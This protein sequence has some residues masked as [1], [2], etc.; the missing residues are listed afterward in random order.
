[1]PAGTGLSP[2]TVSSSGCNNFLS[3]TGSEVPVPS[4][5]ALNGSG[6][7][8][9]VL[10][11]VSQNKIWEFWQFQ[12]NANAGYSACWGG[13]QP[14]NTFTGVFPNPFGLSASG[15][16]YGAITVTEAD[17]ASG[18]INHTIALGI[19]GCSGQVYPADRNDC[20]SHGNN[21][22]QPDEGQWFTWAPGT[23]MP[24]G[25]TPFGQMVFKTIQKYGLVVLD[26]AGAVM[27][28]AEQPSDW[29]AE[30]NTGTDPITASWQGEA[31]YQ[32]IDSL[33]WG[34][35]EAVNPPGAST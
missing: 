15:I 23:K 8:P 29:K 25:L 33:P 32:V 17:V 10:Y 28:E 30:G 14:L 31:E 18:S 26:Y 7:N 34:D 27:I 20:S 1:M 35:L 2:I 6:D 21:S 24:S 19:P 11:S 22:G 9:L 3:S 16:S 4:F 5:V 12:K 13:S